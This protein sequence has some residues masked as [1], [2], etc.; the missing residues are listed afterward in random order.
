MPRRAIMRTEVMLVNRTHSRVELN[1]AEHYASLGYC[2]IWGENS[3]WGNLLLLLMYDV[4]HSP[5]PHSG[6]SIRGSHPNFNSLSYVEGILPAFYDFFG[7]QRD[8]RR[9]LTDN[10]RLHTMADGR[11]DYEGTVWRAERFSIN[12]YLAAIQH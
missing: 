10:Y 7:G 8:L 3:Y 12:D 11:S 6:P 5:Y 1:V 9:A 2:V 4:L